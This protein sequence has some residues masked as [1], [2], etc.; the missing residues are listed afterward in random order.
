[1]NVN[2]FAMKFEGFK[3]RMKNHSYISVEDNRSM[4]IEYCKKVLKFEDNI[5]ELQLAKSAV[6]IIGLNLS[7]KNYAYDCVKVTGHIHSI[8]FE[9]TNERS[10]RNE[11]GEKEKDN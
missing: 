6:R 1:M 11:K 9:N 5:I 4:N 2:K 8:T 7:M 3:D 10:E